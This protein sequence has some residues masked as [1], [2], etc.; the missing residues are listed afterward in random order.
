MVLQNVWKP[1]FCDFCSS[2]STVSIWCRNLSINV[3]NYIISRIINWIVYSK[4]G[5]KYSSLFFH[6]QGSSLIRYVHLKRWCNF[7]ITWRIFFAYLI[8]LIIHIFSPYSWYLFS[9]SSASTRS[10]DSAANL[11]IAELLKSLKCNELWSIWL[12]CDHRRCR[13]FVIQL[14][15]GS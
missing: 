6:L 11:N 13:R 12:S 14:R 8:S 5:D 7:G 15:W 2:A 4:L 1:I 3:L 9:A 10:L